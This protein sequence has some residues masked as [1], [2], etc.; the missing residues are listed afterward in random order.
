MPRELQSAVEVQLALQTLRTQ[1]MLL[2]LQL[3]STRQSIQTLFAVSQ[4]LVEQSL[5]VLQV[6]KATHLLALQECPAEQSEFVM[7]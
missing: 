3:L 5:L 6:A 2:E 4:I 7:H 1:R